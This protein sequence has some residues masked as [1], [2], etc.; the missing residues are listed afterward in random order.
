MIEDQLPE[1]RVARHGQESPWG[2]APMTVT[3]QSDNFSR[4]K[5]EKTFGGGLDSE[6]QRST[7]RRND[8]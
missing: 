5:T 8:A 4:H 1:R 6:L 2:P 7:R 3:L